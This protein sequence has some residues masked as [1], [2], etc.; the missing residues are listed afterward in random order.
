MNFSH[1]SYTAA[2]IEKQIEALR[3]LR[4]RHP[5]KTRVIVE[6]PWQNGTQLNRDY[7]KHILS[8]LLRAGFAPFA[9]HEFYTRALDDAKPDERSL[10]MQAGFAFHATASHQF[11]FADLGITSGMRAGIEH[12]QKTHG[13]TIPSR[14]QRY[15]SFTADGV[16]AAPV[17]P[18]VVEDSE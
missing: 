6:S 15:L 1:T 11:I 13:I 18:T 8:T 12:F 4:P 16:R 10:G 5:E 2:Q 9:S 14:A 3:T 7:L 17:A